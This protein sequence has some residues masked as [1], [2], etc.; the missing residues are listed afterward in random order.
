MYIIHRLAW[1][2]FMDDT[3]TGIL[4]YFEE[5]NDVSNRIIHDVVLFVECGSRRLPWYPHLMSILWIA[6]CVIDPMIH[7]CLS[8]I[9]HYR[10]AGRIRSCHIVC[11]VMMGHTD[12]IIHAGL[13]L[14]DVCSR[15]LYD[16]A[17]WIVQ[18]FHNLWWIME[19][20]YGLHHQWCWIDPGIRG[21]RYLTLC[22][23]SHDP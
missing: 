11:S 1:L 12:C 3:I 8:W 21:L 20:M 7:V 13:H 23:L 10:W 18:S 14:C 4:V 6:T 9:A 16:H 15:W 5:R 17:R 22:D 2:A 19:L